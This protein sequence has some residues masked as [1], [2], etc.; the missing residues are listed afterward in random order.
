MSGKS[1][2]R[3]LLL[4]TLLASVALLVP[5]PASASPR[6]L[7]QSG[8][9]LT[10]LFDSLEP[11]HMSTMTFSQGHRGNDW[12]GLLENR[13]PGLLPAFVEQGT[14][15]CPGFSQCAGSYTIV[16]TVPGGCYTDPE[17]ETCDVNNFYND[18]GAECTAGEEAAYCG[19]YCCISAQL[20]TNTRATCP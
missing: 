14:G 2:S 1:C 18:P 20:C 19:A 10:T 11:V 16:Y 3:M 13:L 7:T 5:A 6:I 12:K 8:Q 17:D 9:P 15:S 4:L